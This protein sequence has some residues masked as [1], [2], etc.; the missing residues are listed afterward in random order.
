[1]F[2]ELLRTSVL[3]SSAR[4]PAPQTLEPFLAS[5][6]ETLFKAKKKKQSNAWCSGNPPIS[7]SPTQRRP[8]RNPKASGAPAI[9]QEGCA[10][11]L[12]LPPSAHTAEVAP[13]NL[14][15]SAPGTAR[16]RALGGTLPAGGHRLCCHGA[17][18]AACPVPSRA[19]DTWPSDCL[20]PPRARQGWK[21]P[22]ASPGAVCVRVVASGGPPHP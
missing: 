22:R 18:T 6:Q 9:L 14:S 2:S 12:L 8:S 5:D 10:L 16:V 13:L 3:F 15:D 17:K 11:E 20:W 21:E 19:C 1:M 7:P 4:T